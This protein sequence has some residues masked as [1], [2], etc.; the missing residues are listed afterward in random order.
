MN[1]ALRHGV[2]HGDLHAGNLGVSSDN[3]IV[4]YD[5]GLVL[6]IDP[7]V[8]R[9]LLNA[10]LTNNTD[11][12]FDVM[13]SARL[14]YIDDPVI[15]TIQFK[16][17]ISYVLEYI[18]SLDFDRFFQQV[19]ND[20]TLNSERLCFHVD[21]KLFLLSRTMT[22]LEGTCTSIDKNFVYTDVIM[23]MMT[24][25]QNM[26]YIDADL[27]LTKGFVDIQRLF[28]PNTVEHKPSDDLYFSTRSKQNPVPQPVVWIFVYTLFRVLNDL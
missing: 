12:L 17:M 15:G 4:L 6:S 22:L 7:K 3:R 18:L 10:V 24:D 11:M 23:D 5:F 16:R 26:D 14:V 27:V 19:S 25:S 13:V 2:I 8:V 9:A 28:V 20:V 21:S 1:G